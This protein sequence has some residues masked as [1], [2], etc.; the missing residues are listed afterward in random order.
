[1]GL[2]GKLMPIL[3]GGQTPADAINQ[4]Y[5][6]VLRRDVDPVGLSDWEA[7]FKAGASLD[8][9]RDTLAASPEASSIIDPIVRLYEVAFGQQIDEACLSQ[10]A[11][12][13]RD[14]T[15]LETIAK[16]F[17]SSQEFYNRFGTDAG[18]DRSAF[19]ESLYLNGLGRASDEEGKAYWVASDLTDEQLLLGFSESVESIARSYNTT[20]NSCANNIYSQHGE[21]GIIEELMKRLDARGLLNK[22][23]VEFGAWDGIFSSN[24][25]NLIKNKEFSG[26][27]IE[28]D[29]IKFD[30]LCT[31]M[32]K[33][34][35]NHVYTINK[36][37][38]FEGADSLDSILAETEIPYDFDFLSIDVDGCDFYIFESLCVY[39]PK[40][41]CIEYNFSIPNSVLF[42]Q[43]K[44][45]SIKQGA[46]AKSLVQLAKSKKYSLIASTHCNLIFSSDEYCDAIDAMKN[47]ELDELREDTAEKIY[48]FL[49]YDGRVITSSPVINRW[50]KIEYRNNDLQVL[51]SFLIKYHED[52]NFIQN[53]FYFIWLFINRPRTQIYSILKLM[54]GFFSGN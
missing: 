34:E 33:I 53:I 8:F 19:V 30:E 17:T 23:C 49:G 14:G 29:K 12:A 52:Y 43:E 32:E 51:P 40:I 16:G 21:D 41:I 11:K 6:S 9:I 27:L 31:N 36:Y 35:H 42:V 15:S 18:T 10:W 2:Q 4:I 47:Q 7:Q 45:F 44:D 13:L 25:H 54:R 50:H 28:G 48:I 26:I 37:V 24:T 5:L 39:R 20:L 1:M 46:S 3:D 38:D 22:W